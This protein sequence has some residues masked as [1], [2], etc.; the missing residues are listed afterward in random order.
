[1]TTSEHIALEP[2]RQPKEVCCVP[3]ISRLADDAALA[4]ADIFKALADPA[5]LQI[6]DILR[7]HQGQVCVCDLEGVVGLPNPT[8]G[9]RPRQATISHHLKVLRDAGL[10]GSEKHNQWVYYFI[11]PECLATVRVALDHLG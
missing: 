7:Q 8:T 11:R 3:L 1:M 2:L 9:Q 4:L 10:I 5:R 6:L